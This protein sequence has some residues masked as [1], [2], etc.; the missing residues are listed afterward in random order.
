M[1]TQK[2][3]CSWNEQISKTGTKSKIYASSATPIPWK[4]EE[5]EHAT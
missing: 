5:N 2:N 3:L 1:D 4:Y